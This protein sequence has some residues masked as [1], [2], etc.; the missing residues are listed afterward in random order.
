MSAV[1]AG[2]VLSTA[3]D[4]RTR[5]IPN[6]LTGATAIVGLAVAAFGVG[7]VTLAQA[8]GGLAIGLL[9]M[10]PGHVIG[11]TGA[12]DVKLFAALGTFLGPGGALLA[13]LY[14]AMAGGALALAVALHRRLLRDTLARAATLVTTGGLNAG[15][16]EAIRVNRFA[17]APAIAI[18]ALAVAL[19]F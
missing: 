1:V 11:A 4:L 15:E 18:G 7:S 12:G 13:F 2:G 17:Y 16:I 5:R 10:L 8:L 9:V 14:T 6:V 3:I 19:G